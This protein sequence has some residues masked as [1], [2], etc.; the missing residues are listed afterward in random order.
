MNYVFFDVECANCLHGEGKICSLGYVKTDDS[1]NILKKKDILVDPD[2]KF[3]LGNAKN[4]KGIHLAYPLFRFGQAHSFPHY[5][6]EIKAI[7]TDPNNLIFGFAVF[8][9]VSYVA[10]SCRRYNLPFLSYKF[11]D[12]QKMEKIVHQNKNPNGLDKLVAEYGLQSFTYHR[13]DDDA[14]MTM[15]IYQ[16]LLKETGLTVKQS[17]KKYSECLGD[18]KKVIAEL[19]EHKRQ[20]AKAQDRKKKVT[21]FFEM[22]KQYHPEAGCYDANFWQKKLFFEP[23][24]YENELAYLTKHSKEIIHKGGIIVRNPLEADFIISFGRSTKVVN[25]KNPN[26]KYM[27]F[28]TFQTIL[29]KK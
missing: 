27:D 13:S 8:Q 2:A 4:G 1:F 6:Q 10:Y 18:S 22:I 16:A 11:F 3:L 17:L 12:I 5:Y 23:S 26:T 25:S 28:S 14:H 7:L 20:K 19:A 9:D 21:E 29:K 24:V 15:E